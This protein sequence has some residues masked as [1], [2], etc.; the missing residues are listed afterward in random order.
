MVHAFNPS[1]LEAESGQPDLQT[2]FQDSQAT[3]KN[4][5]LKTKKEKD[6]YT[7]CNRLSKYLSNPE[8]MA[9]THN[10]NTQETDIQIKSED[11]L[12]YIVRPCLKQK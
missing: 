11:S 8:E 2:E 1:T 10:T 12:G 5:G 7:K 3:Q 9:Y 6:T 4:P